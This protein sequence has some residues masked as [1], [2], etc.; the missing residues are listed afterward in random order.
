VILS[1]NK[2]LAKGDF[3]IDDRTANGAG[4]F[5]GKHIQFGP[6]GKDF[7]DWKAVISYMKHLA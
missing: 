2:H 7:A 1:H 6:E 5:A 4:D 3:L